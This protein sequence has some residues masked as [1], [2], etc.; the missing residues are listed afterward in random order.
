MRRILTLAFF[1]FLF[2]TSEASASVSYQYV[3]DAVSNGG[4]I[5]STAGTDIAIKVY[6]QETLTSGSTSVINGDGG[7]FGFGTQ[8]SVASGASTTINAGSFAFD[9][10]WAPGG[11]F[12]KFNPT[13][14]Q[15][16]SQNAVGSLGLSAGGINTTNALVA[17]GT[18]HLTA[19]NGDTVF[20]I[21]S[22]KAF[23]GNTI[24]SNNNFDLDQNSA[25]PAFTGALAATPYSFTVHVGAA[26]PEPGSIALAGLLVSG[27][28]FGAW[29]R[30]RS[31]IPDTAGV[32]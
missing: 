25:N 28:G 13:S 32:A 12:N 14:G 3:T 31:M 29:R 22:N 21:T 19:G 11:T 15:V 10:N 7:L 4:T 24:T 9:P 23:A 18:F 5:N 30:R 6:L 2:L 26:V 1:A 17:L 8:L 27:I 20:Q 16:T